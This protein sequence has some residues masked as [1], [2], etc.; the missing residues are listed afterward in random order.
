MK[1][2]NLASAKVRVVPWNTSIKD[3]IMLMRDENISSVLV[4]DDNKVLVGLVT[5]RDVVQKL[6]LNE[7]NEKL[8]YQVN[9]LMTRPVYF[10][11]HDNILPDIID[12]H[13]EHSMRHFPII[14]GEC[15]TE[16]NLVGI[17]MATDFIRRYLRLY[18]NNYIQENETEKAKPKA[19]VLGAT[20]PISHYI[21]C[22][23]STLTSLGVQCSI[24]S[25]WQSILQNH[26]ER[27]EIMIHDLDHV[28]TE[29]NSQIIRGLK[30][31]KLPAVLLTSEEKLLV[32]FRSH[33]GDLKH[34]FCKPID[35]SYLRWLICEFY[36]EW[37]SKKES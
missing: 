4:K 20:K 23:K 36:E 30:D 12:L 7:S 6:T 11:R 14:S 13:E 10:V 35:L 3:V 22:L 15:H 33:L 19:I 28:D 21:T 29:V 34:I 26:A 9:T 32:P 2:A 24:E 25:D 17:V 27:T 1:L 5:E 31:S 16:D 8:D 37:R 18:L